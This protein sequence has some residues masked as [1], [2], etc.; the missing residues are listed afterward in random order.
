M[1]TFL[2]FNLAQDIEEKKSGAEAPLFLQSE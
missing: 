2:K 1:I